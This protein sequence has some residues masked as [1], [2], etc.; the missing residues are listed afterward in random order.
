[1]SLV[2]RCCFWD[3]DGDGNCAIHES[4]GVY[5]APYNHC[6]SDYEAWDLWRFY[7]RARN[8]HNRLAKAVKFALAYGSSP[9]TVERL[10]HQFDA[11]PIEPRYTLDELWPYHTEGVKPIVELATPHLENIVAVFADGQ[12][13]YTDS[14]GKKRKAQDTESLKRRVS[15]V[16]QE[17]L[18]RKT[19][20]TSDLQ[21]R[22]N[23]TKLRM[24]QLTTRQNQPFNE[25]TSAEMHAVN[26]H[27]LSLIIDLQLALGL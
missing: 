19:V 9:Q 12:R 2:T 4:P 3:N 27:A 24:S 21:R 10:M 22:I 15:V 25:P 11:Q 8:S 20:Q 13:Y 17:L 23:D 6:K 1:M 26:R 16:K 18:K 7:N 5:R 14:K